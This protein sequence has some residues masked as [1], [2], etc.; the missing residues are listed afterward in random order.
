MKL[1]INAFL[2]FLSILFAVSCSSVKTPDVKKT[3][4]II[5][6]KLENIP[7]MTEVHSNIKNMYIEGDIEFD[8][9]Q[10]S[11]SAS[12]ELTIAGEDSL[13]L[14]IKGPFGIKAGRLF[15]TKDI[16]YFINYISGDF[17][18]GKPSKENFLKAAYI[19]LSYIELVNILKNKPIYQ[20]NTYK[21]YKNYNSNIIYLNKLSSETDEVIY[22]KDNNRFLF[23]KR[24]DNIN[25]ELYSV[26]YSNFEALGNQFPKRIDIDLKQLNGKITLE[27]DEVKANVTIDKPLSFKIPSNANVFNLDETND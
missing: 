16:F 23:T 22:N 18:K 27:Y 19:P 24:Y 12:F 8:L 25:K 6:E 3:E 17:Y 21:Y 15:V 4:P 14:L 9:P 2:G 26:S 11:N 1:Y 10:M 13:G 5:E 20:V 7:I